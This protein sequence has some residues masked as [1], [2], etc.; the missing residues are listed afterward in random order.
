L[1][2]LAVSPD[3][4]RET[5]WLK[6]IKGTIYAPDAPTCGD[7]VIDYFVVS[8]GLA[9]AGAVVAA[10]TIGDA[11]F[12][13]HSPARLIVKTKSREVMVRHL[14][15]PAGFGSDLPFGPPVRSCTPLALRG[16][17]DSMDNEVCSD[18]RTID[19]FGKDYVGLI[20][21]IENELC[22]VAGLEGLQAGAR[23]GRAEGAKFCWKPAMG[24][25]TAGATK[26]TS[27]SRACRK[28]RSGL[29]TSPTPRSPR[30]LK[31]PDGG[32][33]FI[34][35]PGRMQPEQAKSSV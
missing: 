12:N 1:W 7:R 33:A 6:T 9:Q 31:P 5:G 24:D 2:R 23:Q 21:T 30:M 35:I 17:D 19:D 15:V 16:D 4:L 22:A 10:C 26:I 27:A 32:S 8:D 18:M 29:P 34:S 14:K 28:Q 3:E 13:P 25:D 11:G 20:T